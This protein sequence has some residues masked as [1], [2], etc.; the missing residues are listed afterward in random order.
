M[1]TRVP[2]IAAGGAGT[3]VE[4]VVLPYHLAVATQ[5]EMNVNAIRFSSRAS[6]GRVPSS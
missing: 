5:K 6:D 1:A 2:V 4:Q 3:A